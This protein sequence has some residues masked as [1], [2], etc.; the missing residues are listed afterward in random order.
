MHK[1]I[2]FLYRS[3]SRDIYNKRFNS[4]FFKKF[5][6]HYIQKEY[7]KDLLFLNRVDISCLNS[8][9]LKKNINFDYKKYLNFKLPNESQKI[10][11]FNGH[12]C[13]YENIDSSV[14][15]RVLDL[16][17]DKVFNDI[18]NYLFKCFYNHLS[19]FYILNYFFFSKIF[20][21]FIKEDVFVKKPLF[22]LNF[23]NDISFKSVVYPKNVIVIGKNSKINILEGYF[24]LAK[25]MF[26][27]ASTSLFLK[28][29]SFVNH[30]L[31]NSFKLS[32]LNT[33]SLFSKQSSCSK[34][35]FSELLFGN[36][37]Y[38]GFYNF[39]LCGK[40]SFLKK[41]VSKF[42]KNKSV[43]Y[44]DCNIFHGTGVTNSDVSYC[45]VGDNES[46]A[47]FRG[48]IFVDINLLKVSA[49]LRCDGLLLSNHS[50]VI[51][52][53]ELSIKS[54]DIKCSHASTVGCINSNVVFYMMSRGISKTNCISIIISLFLSQCL[55]KN[56]LFFNILNDVIVKNYF[57]F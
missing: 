53:P 43:D 31:I 34:L 56:V 36:P 32:L 45:V 8:C 17:S 24:S 5:L 21:F 27:N 52:S 22:I 23:F 13:F 3:L 7:L 40:S 25:N 16:L 20:Y 47:F 51:L 38:K 2:S 9:N 18:K 19:F 54:S 33:Y 41:R 15:I 29:G 39:F 37:F 10:I 28:H 4:S 57:T 50:K 1:N 26:V 44:M 55:D 35:N 30:H 11:F 6:T 49:K 42:L 48:N 14:N 46:K 12:F